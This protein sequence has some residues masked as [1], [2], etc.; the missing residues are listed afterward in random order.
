MGE[1]RDELKE[2]A[3]KPQGAE[4][5]GREDQR[6]GKHRK[7]EAVKTEACDTTWQQTHYCRQYKML[8]RTCSSS[9]AIW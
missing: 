7:G 1:G 3:R 5:G 6:K 4:L 8:T 9:I 2:S